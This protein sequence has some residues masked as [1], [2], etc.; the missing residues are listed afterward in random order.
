MTWHFKKEFAED[1][2]CEDG[3]T[4]L[5][6]LVVLVIITLIIGIAGP[7]VLR[8]FGA[9]KSNTA[10]IESNRL[11]TDMEFFRVDVGRFPSETEGLDALLTQPD[12]L[13]GWE[14]PYLPKAT[15]KIDP[16]GRDYIYTLENDGQRAV[17]SSLGADGAEG[18]SGENQDVSS[19]D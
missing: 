5:E 7:L 13:V 10:R 4:L 12:G 16:W 8:Q 6:L 15:Q 18:G 9:A 1:V 14:G 11:V 19:K 17:V 2:S 3:Y